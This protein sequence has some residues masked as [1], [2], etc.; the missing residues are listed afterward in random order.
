L[1]SHSCNLRLLKVLDI[2][3]KFSNTI[4]HLVTMRSRAWVS[5]RVEPHCWARGPSS[6]VL[7]P[8][9]TRAKDPFQSWTNLSWQ[10]KQIDNQSKGYGTFTSS[11]VVSRCPEFSLIIFVQ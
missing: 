2:P 6:W 4:L 10:P 1:I 3:R 7:I 11:T 9:P 5:T 8:V